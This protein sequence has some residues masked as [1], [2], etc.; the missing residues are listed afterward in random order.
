[1]ENE[2]RGELRI[3]VRHENTADNLL[4]LT[5]ICLGSGSARICIN[6]TLR[7]SLY[8]TLEHHEQPKDRFTRVADPGHKSNTDIP[9]LFGLIESRPKDP[10][11]G[12][13]HEQIPDLPV[14][15]WTLPL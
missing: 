1:M 6:F 7:R 2:M 15:D 14:Q 13:S 5:K 8:G 4:N 12:Y 9:Y 10:E 3:M 11:S